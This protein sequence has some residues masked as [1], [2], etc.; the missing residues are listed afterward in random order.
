MESLIGRV[1][2][3]S[4][5]AKVFP[6]AYTNIGQYLE[7]A[8]YLSLFHPL[9]FECITQDGNRGSFVRQSFAG[10]ALSYFIR[11]SDTIWS[12]SRFVAL[13]SQII[14]YLKL[15]ARSRNKDRVIREI[16]ADC[17]L[18]PFQIIYRRINNN[19]YLLRFRKLLS[20]RINYI[21]R[22]LIIIEKME[23]EMVDKL[24]FFE[25]NDLSAACQ[26]L[27]IVFY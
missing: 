4:F 8:F 14:F 9:L 27:S 17:W 21:I 23:F 1:K 19:S 7:K 6:N 5:L 11:Q 13:Q 16:V 26:G 25:E 18:S 2:M 3:R 15:D 12:V 10:V 24:I 20:S 22:F